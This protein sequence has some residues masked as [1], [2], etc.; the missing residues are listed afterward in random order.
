MGASGA[1]KTTLLNIIG[2]I[3]PCNPNSDEKKTGIANG[4]LSANSL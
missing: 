4:K 1:G 3:I 2:C